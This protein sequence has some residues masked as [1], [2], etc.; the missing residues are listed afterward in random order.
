MSRVAVGTGVGSDSRV[1]CSFGSCCCGGNVL[2]VAVS[3]GAAGVGGRY[4]G[5]IDAPCI[6]RYD[7]VVT[8][9]FAGG[10]T[11]GGRRSGPLF[12][13][14]KI[15]SNEEWNSSLVRIHR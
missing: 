3:G 4:F 7:G 1:G 9:G 10:T 11:E 5:S 6:L 15:S 8:R 2:S 14:C 12:I 13:H